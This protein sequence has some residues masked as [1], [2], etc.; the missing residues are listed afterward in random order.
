MASL[1]SNLCKC[2]IMVGKS[3]EKLLRKLRSRKY[4][5]EHGLFVAEGPKVVGDLIN[6][7]LKAENLI[8]CDPGLAE[9]YS[10]V[11]IDEK[12]FKNLSQLE[13]ANNILAI[14]HFP[15]FQNI[16][17]PDN[18]LVL[19]KINDPG[20]LGTIIRTSHWFGTELIYCVK[21]TADIYNAKCIQSTM[22][23][24]AGVKVIYGTEEEILKELESYQ[25]WIADM[26]GEN[27]FTIREQKGKNAYIMG[28]E[29]HGP[30]SF[31]KDQGRKITIPKRVKKGEIE[32]L[33][34]AQATAVILAHFS[35][36][37]FE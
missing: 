21:G 24:I 7:G 12:E 32:S 8:T 29:S 13:T 33:N 3:V 31:W 37:S 10:V 28:S 14:F 11:L 26:S 23:S 17:R 35:S 30:S 18:V 6:S 16:S 2:K 1:R 15:E 5:W 20:N 36:L 19:D 25:L 22:G 34:V 9:E 4:R 27:V